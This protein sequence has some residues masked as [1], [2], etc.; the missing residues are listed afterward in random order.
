MALPKPVILFVEGEPLIR[1]FAADLLEDGGFEVTEAATE[2][3]LLQPC[4][5]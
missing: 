4:S 5:S 2:A 3:C 1:M